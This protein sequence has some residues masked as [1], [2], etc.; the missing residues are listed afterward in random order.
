MNPSQI[1]RPAGPGITD[2]GSPRVK[3]SRGF[4]HI[5]FME[6]DLVRTIRGK[7]P[8]S[9]GVELRTV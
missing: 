7:F 8:S 1:R 2:T 6:G 5:H 9:A 4:H 3:L